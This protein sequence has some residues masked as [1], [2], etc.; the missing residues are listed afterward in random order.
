M[1]IRLVEYP[2]ET[3]GNV[4]V[5]VEQL[6][7]Q[8][9]P[10]AAGGQVAAKARE[11]F[12]SALDSI[13]PVIDAIFTRIDKLAKAPDTCEVEFGITFGVEGKAVI[14]AGTSTANFKLKLGWNLGGG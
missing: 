8:M 13:G 4:L 2:L 10:A 11:T 5:A 3:G 14:V 1:T 7:P 9:T 12:E 6:V